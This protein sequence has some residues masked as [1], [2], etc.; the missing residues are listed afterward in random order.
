MRTYLSYRGLFGMRHYCYFQEMQV[1]IAIMTSNGQFLLSIVQ[2]KSEVVP[3]VSPSK[4]E[5]LNVTLQ[6]YQ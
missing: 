3:V 5:P 1:V 4:Q 6:A 2:F